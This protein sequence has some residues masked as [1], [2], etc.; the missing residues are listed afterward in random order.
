MNAIYLDFAERKCGHR[1]PIQPSTIAILDADRKSLGMEIGPQFVACESCKRVYQV[2]TLLSRPTP[3]GLS[4]YNPDAPMHVF[5][6][7]VLCGVTGCETPLSVIAVRNRNTSAEALLAESAGWTWEGLI[8]PSGD[9][10][11]D[12]KKIEQ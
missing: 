4:P 10:I 7:N 6:M 3:S 2:E 5:R 1:A 11:P 9:A 12:R 8:C